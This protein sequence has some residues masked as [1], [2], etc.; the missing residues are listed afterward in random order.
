MEVARAVAR[1]RKVLLTAGMLTVLAAVWAAAAHAATS[2]AVTI[3]TDPVE[4]VTTQLGVTGSTTDSNQFA[5][6]HYKPTGGTACGANPNADDGTNAGI[7]Y[8]I[9]PGNFATSV[10]V[11]FDKAGSYL[12]CAWVMQNSTVTATDSKTVTVRIP[13]LSLALSAPGAVNERDTFQLTATLQAEAS[14]QLWVYV[15][16]DNGRGCPANAGAADTSDV[17]YMAA[18]GRS[19]VGGPTA[20][21]ENLSLG[22]PGVY[23]LCGYMTISGH[24]S[25]PPEVATS[26]SLTVV[27]PP[28]PPPPCVVPAVVKDE[29]LA[30]TKGRLGTASCTV[31]K[32]RYVAS[33]RYA[34]GSVFKLAP[35][36]GTSLPNAA[37]VDVWV[38][39]GAPCIV[40]SLPKTRS[41]GSVTRRLAQAGCTVGKVSHRHSRTVRRGRVIG[42]SAPKGTRLAPRT[43]VGIV[44]SRGR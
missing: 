28:P 38:S 2:V 32:V 18:S 25:D 43:A 3:G 14:R 10:N 5:V 16:V 26:A 7:N 21:S 6:V 9:T 12:A 11:T 40:P 4:S 23:L 1:I 19:F 39:S 29:P 17:A 13:H 44:I 8:T 24:P 33:A 30:A 31:G 35:T 41:L 37:A 27:A 36:P 42:L 15:L 34:R 22:D 20:V